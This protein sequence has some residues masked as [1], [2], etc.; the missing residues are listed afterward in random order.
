MYNLS[1]HVVIRTPVGVRIGD[2]ALTID[3]GKVLGALETPFFEPQFEGCL[4]P[5]DTM[6]LT[7]HVKENDKVLDCRSTGR[8]SSYA[9][10]ISI[11]TESFTYEIDGTVTRAKN[12]Y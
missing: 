10:H 2:V 8:I 7:V 5:D 1:Y 4:H 12:K 9:I 11:P 6:E 3:D